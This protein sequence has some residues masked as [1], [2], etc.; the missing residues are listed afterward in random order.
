MRR[1]LRRYSLAA[2]LATIALPVAASTDGPTADWAVNEFGGTPTERQALYAGQPGIILP[3]S[4]AS[5]LFIAWQRLHGHSVATAA[6]EAL[7]APC[8]GN[9]GTS[10][11]VTAWLDARKA[12]P[13]N[14]P[15]RPNAEHRTPR[16]GLHQH[17]QLPR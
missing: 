16:P 15:T 6:G 13:G 9:G 8:C 11:A 1:T 10:D 5:L 12:V 17:P 2:L 4:P 3:T 7:A 14:R